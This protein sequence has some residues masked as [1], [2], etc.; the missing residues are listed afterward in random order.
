MKKEVIPDCMDRL[1]HKVVAFCLEPRLVW[2]LDSQRKEDT[3]L[4]V[5]MGSATWK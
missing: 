4:T 1:F 5:K 2:L 3:V